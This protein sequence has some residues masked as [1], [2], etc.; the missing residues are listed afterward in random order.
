MKERLKPAVLLIL[1]GWGVAPP[2]DSNAIMLAKTP[3]MDKL[4]STYPAM[5]LSASGTE[6]GLRTGEMGNS[7]VGHL[8]IGA[9]QV[10]YQTLPRIN[11][12]IDDGAFLNNPVF[13][14]ACEHVKHNKTKL[15]IMG[16]VS[17]GGVH[18]HQ[19][20]LYALLELAKKH[21]VKEVY[22]HV[23]LDGRDTIYNSGK[24]FII[25]L[26]EKMKELKVGKIATI[27]GRFY[28]MDRD[29]RWDRIEKTYIAMTSGVGE[30]SKDS[31]KALEESYEKKVYDEEFVPTVIEKRMGGPVAKVEDNDAVIFFNFRA[32]RARQLTKAFVEDNFQG[33]V[34]SKKLNLKF[35][36]MAEYEKN[37]PV[38]I[39]YP[40]VIISECLAKIISDNNLRQ[41]HIAETEKYAHVTFF[42]NGQKEG[43]Y[44]NEDRMIIPSPHVSSYDKKPEMSAKLIAEEIIKQIKAEKYDFIV[45][46]FA[47]ADMVA[48]TGNF[49]A[50][51]KAISILDKL[52]G[53]IVQQ[54]L[55]F[56]GVAFITADHGNAEQMTNLQTSKMD[57]EHSTNPVPFL[58]IGEEYE[59]QSMGLPAG[60]GSDLSLLPPVGILGDVA[61]TI[62]K[63]LNLPQPPEMTGHPLI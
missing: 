5:T 51:I 34:R 18:S 21:K 32:D 13:L 38:A 17:P 41:F 35:V 48:H 47:N 1:D 56:G 42:L 63:V 20:H 2:G 26:Q 28:A 8:N 15:H 37:L 49:E 55:L 61:P 52:I 31:L 6:V 19:E 39:A 33:F 29:N 43:A 3:N 54:I 27:S 44:P 30:I 9:G 10:Y 40:P 57:K 14:D 16:L 53:D 36:A 46:N 45:A 7:E 25:K 23:F 4:T 22:V 50:T 24:N 62:L 12:D 58:I 11:K 59:G 60:V